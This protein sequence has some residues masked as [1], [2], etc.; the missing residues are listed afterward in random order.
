LKALRSEM[1]VAQVAVMGVVALVLLR[2]T[3]YAQANLV[4]ERIMECEG[5]MI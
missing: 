1:T 3:I 2:Q 5:T 4:Y